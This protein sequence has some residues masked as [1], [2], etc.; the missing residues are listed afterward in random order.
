MAQEQKIMLPPDVNTQQLMMILNHVYPVGSYYETSD[1]NFDPNDS[2][3]GEWSLE[4]SGRV[5][6]SAGTGYAIGSKG[7][8]TE[9]P[10]HTHTLTRSTNVGVSITSSGTCTI[11]SSGGHDHTIH[12]KYT[13][14]RLASGTARTQ[15][16]GSGTSTGTSMA[17]IDSNT[18][19]HTHTV[20]N[21]THTTS[22]TQPVFTCNYAG[23]SGNNNMQPYI[24]VNRWHRDR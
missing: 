17:Q 2:F 21:H 20:P 9:V 3:V 1:E 10:Y 6:V 12:A 5:H 13:E 16:Y 14:N 15:Y 8:S 11:T 19:K 24:V 4:E 18:G 23:T 22:V 7:G